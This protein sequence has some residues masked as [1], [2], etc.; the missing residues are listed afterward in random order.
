MAK[1]SFDQ[2]LQYLRDNRTWV[3][4]EDLDFV[5]L[6]LQKDSKKLTRYE[7]IKIKDIYNSFD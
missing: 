4:P 6:V 3:D 1:V 2:M 5:D 7:K